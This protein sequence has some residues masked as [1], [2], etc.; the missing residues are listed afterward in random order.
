MSVM[1]VWDD[2]DSKKKDMRI[3]TREDKARIGRMM[4]SVIVR[5][6]AMNAWECSSSF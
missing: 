6:I 2:V 5:V 3:I 4:H 1:F